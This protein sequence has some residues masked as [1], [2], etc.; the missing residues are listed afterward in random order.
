VPVRE[1]E[2]EQGD[3]DHKGA[4]WHRDNQ[5]QLCE[6]ARGMVTAP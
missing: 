5:R 1:P 6:P 3:E 4:E 2:H